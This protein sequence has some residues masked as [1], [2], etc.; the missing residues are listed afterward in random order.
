MKRKIAEELDDSS[1]AK[2]ATV[3]KEGDMKMILLM[4][5][6]MTFIIIIGVR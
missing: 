3:Q 5:F 1:V 4:R 6:A 2:F